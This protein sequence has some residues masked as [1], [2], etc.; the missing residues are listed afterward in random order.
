MPAVA[1][2][3]CR[4]GSRPVTMAMTAM[5][6]P[7]SISVRARFVVTAYCKRASKSVTT[8]TT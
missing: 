3:W 2:P 5:R 7:V 1:M 6:M 8:P 4:R